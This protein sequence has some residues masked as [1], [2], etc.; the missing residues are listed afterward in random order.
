MD[1]RIKYMDGKISHRSARFEKTPIRNAAKPFSGGRPQQTNISQVFASCPTTKM[2]SNSRLPIPALP[3][4]FP[5][6]QVT[7]AKEVSW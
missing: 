2:S 5:C 1:T 4:P 3:P 7:F 6:R